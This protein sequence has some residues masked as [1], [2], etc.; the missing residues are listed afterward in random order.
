MDGDGDAVAEAC[1]SVVF[2]SMDTDVREEK[3][4]E[5]RGEGWRGDEWERIL[6]ER[7]K[8]EEAKLNFSSWMSVTIKMPAFTVHV[9]LEVQHL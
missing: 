1:D 7:E 9:F 8:G 2:R 3:I 4:R 6:G 5:G